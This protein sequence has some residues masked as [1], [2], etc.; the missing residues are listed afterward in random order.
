MEGTG[1]FNLRLTPQPDDDD[2]EI[3]IFEMIEKNL[4]LLKLLF[5]VYKGC[6]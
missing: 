6:R 1:H 5:R 2:V 4:L 3:L